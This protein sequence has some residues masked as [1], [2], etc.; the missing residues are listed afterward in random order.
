MNLL[1]LQFTHYLGHQHYSQLLCLQTNTRS[2]QRLQRD[3]VI[4][5]DHEE[6]Y[7]ILK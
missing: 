2:I 6:K 7:I 5:S 4:S 1:Q 3:Y